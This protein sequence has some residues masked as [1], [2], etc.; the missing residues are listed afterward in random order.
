MIIKT[1]FKNLLQETM[2]TRFDEISWN[3]EESNII[4]VGIIG[5]LKIQLIISPHTY[6]YRKEKKVY[7]FLNLIFKT[8]DGSSYSE[9][10][11]HIKTDKLSSMISCITLALQDKIKDYEWDW[12]T[13][14]A[15]NNINSRMKLYSR[16][17]D[18]ISKNM[19]TKKIMNTNSNE[20]VIM[21][22]KNGIDIEGIW[23]SMK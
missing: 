16:I 3:H 4:G 14:I 19:N 8:W 21:L 15:K 20:G 2:N 18:V 10:M 12:F 7:T 23:D 1:S 9:E 5:D 17:A 22:A 13:L 11:G 6:R